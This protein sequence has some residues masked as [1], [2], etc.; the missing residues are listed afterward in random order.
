M[1]EGGVKGRD[2]TK[3]T[4]VRQAIS[5]PINNTLTKCLWRHFKTFAKS[6]Y[7]MRKNGQYLGKKMTVVTCVNNSQISVRPCELLLKINQ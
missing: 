7:P 1:W 4:L 2:A 6:Y 3:K 5:H